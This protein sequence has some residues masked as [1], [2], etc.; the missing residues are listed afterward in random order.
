MSK[1]RVQWTPVGLRSLRMA[2]DHVLGIWGE[3][4]A[5]RF[6]AAIDDTLAR[7][8]RFPRIAATVEG[9][10]FRRYVLHRHVSL[11]YSVEQERIKVLLIWDNRM[12]DKDLLE[13]LSNASED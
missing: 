10:T 11:F 6:L 12:N 4:V 9:A 3:Q 1:L 7:I 8:Q 5:D 13:R 2:H